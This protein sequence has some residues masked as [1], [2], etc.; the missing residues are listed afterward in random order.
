MRRLAWL[1]GTAA[2]GFFATA[3][4]AQERPDFSGRWTSESAVTGAA[5]GGGRQTGAAQG[6]RGRRGGGGRGRARMGDMGSGFGPNITITQDANQ[7]TIEYPFFARGD[8]QPPLL[9]VYALDGSETTNSV[10]MGQGRQEQT[11]TTTWEGGTFVISTRHTLTHPE[12]GEAIPVHVRQSLSLE[13]P[14]S[15]LIE[16]TRNGVLGGEPST[17]RTTYRKVE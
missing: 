16:A 9:F 10:T 2:I 4:P 3:V 6:Q 12:T 14:T 1:A 15:L 8:L 11:S 17:T 7:L 13:S 5:R